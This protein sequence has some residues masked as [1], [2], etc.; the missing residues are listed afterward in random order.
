MIDTIC[1]NPENP[2]FQWNFDL[3]K[4]LCFVSD[5]DIYRNLIE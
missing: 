1:E 3:T 2:F 4:L 5:F